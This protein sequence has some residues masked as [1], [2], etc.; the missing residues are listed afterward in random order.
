MHKVVSSPVKLFFS[1]IPGVHKFT[2]KFRMN[3]PKRSS[4]QL[5]VLE[6]R[7][8]SWLFG[9]SSVSSA[10]LGGVF[11]GVAKGS[12]LTLEVSRLESCCLGVCNCSQPFAACSQSGR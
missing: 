1:Q 8:M 9:G 11:S 2:S 12:R 3:Q 5:A 10:A 6:F 7:A 4:N